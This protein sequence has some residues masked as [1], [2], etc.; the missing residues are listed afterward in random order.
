MHLIFYPF[1]KVFKILKWNSDT[2]Q[3]LNYFT[4]FVESYLHKNRA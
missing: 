1:L 4:K 2:F 3:I